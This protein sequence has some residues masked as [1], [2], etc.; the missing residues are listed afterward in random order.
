VRLS[1]AVKVFIPTMLNQ[2]PQMTGFHMHQQTD[3]FDINSNLSFSH[4]CTH[5]ITVCGVLLFS[6][7]VGFLISLFSLHSF[8]EHLIL[9]GQL[10][11]DNFDHFTSQLSIKSNFLCSSSIALPTLPPNII[12]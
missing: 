2:I 6:I 4:F 8:V 9:I 11:S 1:S 12:K 10:Q 3:L 7:Q 5:H